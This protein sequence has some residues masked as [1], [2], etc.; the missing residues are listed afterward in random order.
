[1][2]R[3]GGEAPIMHNSNINANAKSNATRKYCLLATRRSLNPLVGA[4]LVAA[5]LC[6]FTASAHAQTQKKM[7][8]ANL[9]RETV[10]ST[11]SDATRSTNSSGN[12]ASTDLERRDARY[13]LCASDVI[14]LEFPLTPEFN[15]TVNIQPDGFVS[16][17]GAGDVHLEGLTTE[18]AVAAIKKAYAGVLLDPI[19]TVELRDFN[20]P[21]FVVT[22][23]VNK[24]GKYELRGYTSATEAVAIA[25]GF[26]D[27]AKHSQVLLF[28]RVN[29]DWYEVKMLDLKKILKG[30]DVNEDAEI[31]SGDMLFVPQNFMSKVKKYIPSTGVGTYYE[32]YR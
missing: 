6:L 29:N 12:A 4:G 18:E 13:R 9:G 30:R 26:N 8:A 3:F 27:S 19:V 16:L 23:Q 20:K 14:A 24:P 11:V 7:V 21:Y 15:Q 31:R 28:R 32:L 25:G 2:G 1:M 5:A 10:R 17:E 22:G